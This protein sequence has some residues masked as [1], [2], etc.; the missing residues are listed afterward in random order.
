MAGGGGGEVVVEFRRLISEALG[1]IREEAG[2][3][4]MWWL[5]EV[6]VWE[7][8]FGLFGHSLGISMS[9]MANVHGWRVL[10]AVVAI[11]PDMVGR[12]DVTVVLGNA[13]NEILNRFHREFRDRDA[14]VGVVS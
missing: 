5:V 10:N 7:K 2:L 6:E 4:S 9:L 12:I 14:G 1:R 3:A 8:H 11:E 13:F